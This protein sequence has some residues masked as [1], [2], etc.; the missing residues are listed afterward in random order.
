[1]FSA[2]SIM[3][4]PAL[5]EKAFSAC[6]YSCEDWSANTCLMLR[7]LRSRSLVAF[8]SSWFRPGGLTCDC[9]AAVNIH[10]HIGVMAV[11][12]LITA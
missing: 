12:N 4:I 8:G 5:Y 11:W 6:A 10:I 1:M 3:L 2:C 9:W 7:F